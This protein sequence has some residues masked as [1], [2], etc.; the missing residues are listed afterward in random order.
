M[1]KVVRSFLAVAAAVMPLSFLSGEE[2]IQKSAG[3]SALILRVF[4]GLKEGSPAVQSITSSYLKYML[5]ASLPSDAAL[6]AEQNQIQKTFNLKDVKLL[7]ESTKR[8]SGRELIRQL[9]LFRLD[10]RVYEVTLGSKD[11]ISHQFQIE[12]NEVTEKGSRNLL[13][14]EFTI[15]GKSVAVFG[16]EDSQG[17]PYFISLREEAAGIAGGVE[18]GVVGGVE[19]GIRGGVEGGVVGGV[20]KEEIEKKRLDFEKDAVACKGDI[21]PPKLIKKID[22]A[23]PEEARKNGIQGVVILETKTDES[24][25]VRDVLILRS[26]PGLDEAAADAVRQWVYEPLIVQGTPRMALLTTTVKFQLGEKDI[27]QFAKGAVK[28][29]DQIKPPVLI[30]KVDPVYPEE[31]R[32]AGLSGVVILEARTDIQGRVKDVMV[33]KSVPAL[34]QAAIDAVRQWIY[35]PLMIDGKP[36]EAAF[37][38]TV[39]FALAEDKEKA[40]AGKGASETAAEVEPKIIKKVDP[41]YPEA[42]RKSGVQ[43]TV[44]LE[45]TTDAKG[46]VVAVRVLKSVPE[47]D[48]AAVEALRQWKYEP[49]VVDGKPVGLVFTVTIRFALK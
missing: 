28:V 38:T 36:Q 4:E 24:G 20:Q 46:N 29:K 7:T 19:G 16:F 26:V 48:Q 45:A 42:A 22:P 25:R 6:E 18:G 1:K 8:V 14:T 40:G 44:L 15:P 32:K 34:N 41:V 12:V 5:A 21:Q 23:Y 30:K 17:K 35:E 11:V 9:T 31:A 27:E 43:G 37:S 3:G 49:Y 10:G 2:A 39:R 47:L 13:D 33:L